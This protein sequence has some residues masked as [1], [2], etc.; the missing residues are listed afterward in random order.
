MSDEEGRHVE[1]QQAYEPEDVDFGQTTG[2]TP[3]PTFTVDQTTG[4]VSVDW[5]DNR[6]EAVLMSADSVDAIVEERNRMQQRITAMETVLMIVRL[7]RRPNA[8]DWLSA[9]L[10]PITPQVRADLM[11]RKVN[12][13]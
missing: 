2:A 12:H 11:L 1:T 13:R 7:G 3:E 10:P 5:H 9:N 8:A 4:L 6:P